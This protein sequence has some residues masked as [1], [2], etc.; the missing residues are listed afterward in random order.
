M[1]QAFRAPS[2]HISRAASA[3]DIQNHACKGDIAGW[4]NCEPFGSTAGAAGNT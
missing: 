2:I 1:L 3:E 4:G